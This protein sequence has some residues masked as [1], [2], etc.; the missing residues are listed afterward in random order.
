MYLM[1]HESSVVYFEDLKKLEIR[2]LFHQASE[3]RRQDEAGNNITEN[4]KKASIAL[5]FLEAST[6]TQCSFVQ[7]A[8]KLDFKTVVLQGDANS[9]LSKGETLED[10]VLQLASMAVDGLIVRA[11]GDFKIDEVLRK[12][13]CPVIN[14]GWGSHNH[15]TQGL[16]D[17][18]TIFDEL[19]EI[20]GKKILIVG[21]LKHSRCAVSQMEI[22]QHLGA[23]VGISC[24]EEFC[25]DEEKV[26]HIQRQRFSNMTEGLEWADV[27]I[28][29][30]V[31]RERH[32]GVDW[33]LESYRQ[34]FQ[35]SKAMLKNFKQEGLIMAPGPV[36]WGVELNSD[37]Q[38]D[39][40]NRILRQVYN[41][42][43]VRAALLERLIG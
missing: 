41:G 23:D 4:R 30:R 32:G 43:F 14:A 22:F 1:S 42:V 18:F 39:G 27:V 37:V 25:P 11:P 12:V 31:Q 17:A 34:K 29:L 28:A 10:T 6:R 35:I 3:M 24:P 33:N 26:S 21:D 20:K 40:R 5:V 19:G 16:L 36:N 9:S 7:A 8:H 13:S 38:E 15:P 2:S